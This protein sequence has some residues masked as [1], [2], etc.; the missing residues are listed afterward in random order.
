MNEATVLLERFK[1]AMVSLNE[2]ETVSTLA[3]LIAEGVP[4][5]DIVGVLK[6]GMLAVTKMF[7]EGTYYMSGLLLANDIMRVAM[8]R[9]IPLLQLEGDA[10]GKGLVLVGTIEGDIHEIGKNMA[11]WFLRADGFEVVDLGVDIPPRVFLK[12]ILQREPDV[13]GVSIL[14]ADSVHLV[15]RLV[16]LVREVYTDRP[17]PPI[18]VGCSFLKPDVDKE[19]PCTIKDEERQWLEV[20]CVVHDAFD[21][22]EVCRELVEKRKRDKAL[23]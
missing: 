23:T 21:T 17:P 16:S 20:E 7:L 4:P 13:V 2:R 14:M 6:D 9:L 18:F 15:K 8:E 3:A 19:N 11:T 10:K 22:V 12:E 1:N 5:K